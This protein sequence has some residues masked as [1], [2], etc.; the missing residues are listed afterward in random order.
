MDKISFM[1][2]QKLSNP[3]RDKVACRELRQLN[4]RLC[5]L[6]SQHVSLWK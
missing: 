3:E 5:D 2:L 6:E 4:L 1:D